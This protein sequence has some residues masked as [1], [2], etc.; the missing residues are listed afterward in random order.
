M[1]ENGVAPLQGAIVLSF[2]QKLG[3]AL[4]LAIFFL[5]LQRKDDFRRED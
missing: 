2:S 1:R 4:H 5:R 3:K